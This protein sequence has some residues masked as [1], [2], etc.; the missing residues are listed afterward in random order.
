MQKVVVWAPSIH[1]RDWVRGEPGREMN[2]SGMLRNLAT[3][4]HH[5]FCC[6][7]VSICV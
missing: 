7:R 6:I 4:F 3:D 1:F 5:P 2:G